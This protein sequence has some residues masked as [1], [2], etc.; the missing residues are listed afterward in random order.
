[1]PLPEFAIIVPACNEAACL[2]AVLDELLAAV[3]PEKFVVAVG[4]NASSDATARF[5]ARLAPST[6][7]SHPIPVPRSR[8]GRAPKARSGRTTGPTRET[9]GSARRQKASTVARRS[10]RSARRWTSGRRTSTTEGSKTRLIR[11]CTTLALPNVPSGPR[12]PNVRFK[13][14]FQAASGRAA[15]HQNTCRLPRII[16]S[17]RVGQTA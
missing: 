6:P 1:M 17:R 11:R 16:L 3:D 5:V 13:F 10:R 14:V 9:G 7:S 4:V 15:G 12:A 2:G 8:A